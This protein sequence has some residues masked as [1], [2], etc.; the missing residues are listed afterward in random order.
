MYL[1]CHWRVLEE[2]DGAIVIAVWSD[3][4]KQQAS[5]CMWVCRCVLTFPQPRPFNTP[6]PASPHLEEKGIVRAQV[7]TAGWVIRPLDP[8]HCTAS[9][10]TYFSM[11]DL[12]VGRSVGCTIP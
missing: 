3:A 1:L 12:K 5:M 6:F 4:G 2:E 8:P 7:L 9:S 11:A 10:C